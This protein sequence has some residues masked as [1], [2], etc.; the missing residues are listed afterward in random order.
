MINISKAFILTITTL[1]ALSISLYADCEHCY[2]IAKVKL[3][4]KNE[5]TKEGYI[6]IFGGYLDW[7]VRDNITAGDEIKKNLSKDVKEITFVPELYELP[8][9]RMVAC[10]EEIQNFTVSEIDKIIFQ[11]WERV[12]GAGEISNLPRK[13]ILNLKNKEI[14]NI[15]VSRGSVCDV[16]YINQNPEISEKDFNLLLQGRRNEFPV[17]F[18]KVIYKNKEKIKP[19]EPL[20][21]Y[22]LLKVVKDDKK[23]IERYLKSFNSPPKNKYLAQ[24]FDYLT[25]VYN[26]RI[27]FYTYIIYY[28]ENKD[29]NILVY[30]VNKELKEDSLKSPLREELYRKDEKENIPEKKFGNFDNDTEIAYNIRKFFWILHNWLLLNDAE[31]LYEEAIKQNEIIIYEWSFD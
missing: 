11:S 4:F 25:E 27:L 19:E 20:N 18:R 16:F 8:E 10:K 23:Q 31:K 29:R 6:Q 1:C 9:I 5:E 30:F 15:K 2:S 22:K 21:T 17:I 7:R 14:L 12:G 3:L 28:L 13:D 26:R 24:Y